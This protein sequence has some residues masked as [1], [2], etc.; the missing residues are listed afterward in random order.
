[1]S[2]IESPPSGP[3]LARA[4]DGAVDPPLAALP[5]RQAPRAVF[6][7]KDGTVLDDVPY[8]VDPRKMRFAPGARAALELLAAYPYRLIVVSNQGGV[9]QGRFAI[10]ALDAVEHQLRVMFASCGASL[11]AFYSCPH[12]PRGHVVPYASAC[13]CRKPAPG[14]LLQAAHDHGIDLRASWLVGDILDDVEAGNRA[15]CRT[16]LLDNGNETEWRDGP[17]RRPFAYANDLHGAA[18][19]IAC[20]YELSCANGAAPGKAGSGTP[21]VCAGNAAHEGATS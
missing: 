3:A 6:L 10:G 4:H 5:E 2:S 16:I 13:A 15:G 18:R 20:E 9:A 14:M 8:N 21:T 11:D 12:D 17:R 19:L 1:M 7:D